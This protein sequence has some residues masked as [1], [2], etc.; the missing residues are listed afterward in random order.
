M[1]LDTIEGGDNFA[2]VIREKIDISD[3]LLAVIGTHWLT[4][5][6]KSGR[7]RLD[8]PDDFVRSEIAN[9]LELGIRVIPVLVGGSTM[10]KAEDLPLN[11]R[12]LCM[13]QAVEFRDADFHSD[14]QQL[15]QMLIKDLQGIG[16]GARNPKSTRFAPALL[17]GAGAILIFAAFLFFFCDKESS[18][19]GKWSAT[20]KY[21]W[22]DTYNAIFDFEIDN[23]EISGLAGYGA[24]REGDGRAILDGKIAG[25]RIS[26]M[27]KSQTTMGFNQP[28]AEERRALHRNSSSARGET[29][30]A[31]A[32]GW[33]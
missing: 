21:D 5:T 12:E 24:D 2:E 13:R 14:T 25:N 27:T 17:A 33:V 10:P 32:R 23:S 15:T 4:I 19:A 11:L 3:V 7:R 20:V 6:N 22:G 30:L 16:Q 28:N 31:D 9:A 26:F 1:D 8:N 29:T 18:V